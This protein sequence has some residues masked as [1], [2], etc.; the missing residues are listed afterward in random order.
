MGLCPFLLA[1]LVV[2]VVN[3]GN[4]MKIIQLIV[5]HCGKNELNCKQKSVK[6]D[7]TFVRE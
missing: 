4:V 6:E 7:T 2:Q 5:V 3:G 1:L